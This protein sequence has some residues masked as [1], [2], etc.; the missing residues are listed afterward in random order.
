MQANSVSHL[1]AAGRKLLTALIAHWNSQPRDGDVL[2]VYLLQFI[3]HCFPQ[4]KV[5]EAV[6]SGLQFNRMIATIH[7]IATE[8]PGI[9]IPLLAQHIGISESHLRARFRKAVGISLGRYLREHRL[10]ALGDQRQVS[11]TLLR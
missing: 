10:L 5:K 9:Q 11:L 3:R 2:A 4:R 1:D 6:S 7:A 8:R